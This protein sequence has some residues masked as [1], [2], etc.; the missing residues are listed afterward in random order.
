MDKQNPLRL[1]CRRVFQ[2]EERQCRDRDKEKELR[3]QRVPVAT[4]S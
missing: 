1:V 2:P 3:A 4:Q